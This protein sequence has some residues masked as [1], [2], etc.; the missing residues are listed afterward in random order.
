MTTAALEVAE[1]ITKLS[2]DGLP[3]TVRFKAKLCLLDTLGC[4]LG[5][6]YHHDVIKLT[7][8]LRF[9]EGRGDYNLWGEGRTASLGTA[10]IA[11]CSMAHTFDFDD[12]HKKGKVHCGAVIIPAVL[13]MAEH[14]KVVG[15]EI[16]TAIVAGY[17]V[18]LRTAMAVDATAHR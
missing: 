15:K 2:Y 18:M 4:A 10:I 6:C 11:N 12:F 9:L 16:I 14:Q 17:E 1:F 8:A 5:A 7:K 13:A 3:E